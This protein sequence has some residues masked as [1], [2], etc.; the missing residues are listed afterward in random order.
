MPWFKTDDGFWR[1]RKVRKLGRERVSVPALVACTGLWQLAGSWAA[2]NIEHTDGFVPWDVVE[3]WDPKRALAT[4]LLNAGLWEHAEHDGDDGIR[5]HDWPDY[6]PSAAQVIAERT[7]AAERMRRVRGKS[8]RR[9]PERSPE[10]EPNDQENNTSTFAARSDSP[11]PNPSVPTEH[12]TRAT[13]ARGT[14]DF[15]RFWAIYP[16]RVGK[17]AA[18]KAWSK[19]IKGVGADKIIDG[20]GRYAAQR[21]GQDADFTPHPAT[22]LNAGRWDDEPPTLAV[23]ADEEFQLPTPPRA[24]ADDPDPG[25]YVRWA[26]AQRDAW[27]A[28]RTGRSA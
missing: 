5:Y 12:S 3:D 16:R 20:A 17:E 8:Q 9:S 27:L 10:Q 24:I 15:D 28:N 18:R 14:L 1:H 6:N 21:R 13:H 11:Y 25:V 7:A 19:A 23:V 2:E 26:R 22:W 4:R